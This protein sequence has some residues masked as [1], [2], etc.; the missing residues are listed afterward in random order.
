MAVDYNQL[1]RDPKWRGRMS[2]DLAGGTVAQKALSGMQSALNYQA[3]EGGNVYPWRDTSTE[4]GMLDDLHAAMAYEQMAEAAGVDPTAPVQWNDIMRPEYQ[5]VLDYAATGGGPTY[6]APY[7][8]YPTAQGFDPSRILNPPTYTDAWKDPK[9]RG[10]LGSNAGRTTAL[11]AAK[12]NF[13]S[14]QQGLNI[15]PSDDYNAPQPTTLQDYYRAYDDYKT[16]IEYGRAGGDVNKQL[17]WGDIADQSWLDMVNPPAPPSPA[18][19][20]QPTPPPSLGLQPSP[21]GWHEEGPLN[22]NYFPYKGPGDEYGDLR[23]TTPEEDSSA[24]KGLEK[25]IHESE[26]AAEKQNLIKNWY[27]RGYGGQ[28]K[29]YSHRPFG[30]LGVDAT[31]KEVYSSPAPGMGY[32]AVMPP[33]GSRWMYTEDGGQIA[34][35]N[36]AELTD[37]A[38]TSAELAPFTITALGDPKTPIG[39][40]STFKKTD[41]PSP[42]MPEAFRG[43]REGMMAALEEYTNPSTGETWTAGNMGGETPEGWVVKRFLDQYGLDEAMN[44]AA[45]SRAEAPA[46]PQPTPQLTT[47]EGMPMATPTPT[48]APAAAPA[49]APLPAPPAVAP[50]AAPP[51]ATMAATTTTPPPQNYEQLMNITE[52]RVVQPEFPQGGALQAEL[53]DI[54]ELEFEE[55]MEMASPQVGDVVKISEAGLDVSIPSPLQASTYQAFVQ[56]GTPEFTAAQ[57]QVSTQSLVGDIQGAVSQEA[58]AQAATGELDERATVKYQM[59]QLFSSLEEGKP[60][61]AWAAPAVRNVGAIM[62]KRGLGASS[63]AAGAITQAIM[64]SGVPIAAADAKAY[65]T[66]QLQN[67]SNTQQ[68]TLQNAMT[69]AAMDKANLDARMNTAIN[70]SRAFLAIDTANL[71]NK[72]QMQSID[73]QSKYQKLVSDSAA[74]NAALQFNSKTTNQMNEFYEELNTQIEAANKARLSAIRQYNA[75]EDNTGARYLASLEQARDSFNTK[76]QAQINQSN[77]VWR[78]QVNTANTAQQNEV[79]RQ[80]AMNLLNLSQDSLNRLW[81]KYRDDASWIY[82]SAENAITREHQIALYAQQQ[83]DRESMYDKDLYVS[84]FETLGS[85]VMKTIFPHFATTGFSGDNPSDI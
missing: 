19:T 11:E 47:Q 12:Q 38:S 76:L 57:G 60:L 10:R 24:K 81:M 59:G 4:Q 3:S 23:P 27:A 28:K 67:L 65:S 51:A 33:D 84:T 54:E 40:P 22:E 70:N 9:W 17:Q 39:D 74:Q 66:I 44:R 15:N 53:Q 50:A 55:S 77:A 41:E 16:L 43:R 79:N 6:D 45:E 18:P 83:S 1:W 26:N 73:L 35:P 80:N 52:G 75:G 8:R 42:P 63:M 7:M 82:N 20:P 36:E 68:A 61:P 14:A 5:K 69:Y 62:A 13:Q 21:P 30:Q 58:I 25:Q 72:Q 31:Y 29:V 32:L 48:A 78:R 56:E 2:G 85:G 71:T 46:P 64:E 37:P 49:A 34:V